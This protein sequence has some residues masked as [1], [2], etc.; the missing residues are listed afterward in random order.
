MYA[1]R[2]R[3]TH[4]RVLIRTCV[5]VF[6]PRGNT[7]LWLLAPWRALQGDTITGQSSQ[8][9]AKDCSQLWAKDC[10][11]LWGLWA[12]GSSQLWGL[13]AKDSS[14]LWAKD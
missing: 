11:Q 5:Q 10:S 8:L 9:W 2:R 1:R 13:W 4:T 3:Y 14:Q 6:P 7:A 12:K